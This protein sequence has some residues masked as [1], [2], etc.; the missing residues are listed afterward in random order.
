M[1][2]EEHQ[3]F[4]RQVADLNRYGQ[5]LNQ[6]T[7]VEEVVSL[8]MEAITLLFEFSNVTVVEARD[9]ELHVVGSTNP[10]ITKGDEPGEISARA[11]RAGESVTTARSANEDSDEGED[12]GDVDSDSDGETVL[13][14]PAGVVDEV[15][16]I[17]VVHFETTEAFD[18]EYV[19]PLEILASHAATAMS[20]IHSR[21]RLERARQDLETRKEMIEMYDRLLRHDIGNDLQIISGFAEA[22]E[23][24]IEDGQAAEYAAKIERSAAN[25]ADLI[26][27][28]GDLVSTLE[29]QKEPEARPLGP[30]IAETV[31]DVR[32]QYESLTVECDPE[33]FE[34]RVYAGDLLDSVFTNI[35]SNAAVHNEGPVTVELS[36][37]ESAPDRLV[38]EL[39]DDGGGIPDDVADE[40]FE[41]GVK[42]EESEGTGFGLGFV[43]ALTESYGGTVEVRTSEHGGAAFRVTLERA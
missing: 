36:A 12:E 40:L 17:V 4:A 23:S 31:E 33:D 26:S 42:G 5:A 3:E 32:H 16:T 20:N 7:S 34:Y 9:G 8:T 39:A 25:S 21:E 1:S 13:A 24:Q 6:C 41:M 38:V 18:D 30:I 35:L 37:H 27:R 11:Y 14:V 19:T 28:V 15:N 10:D 43:R 22:L 2:F 29:Q